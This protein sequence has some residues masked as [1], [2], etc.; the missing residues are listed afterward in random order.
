MDGG[1]FGAANV[2]L[3]GIFIAIDINQTPDAVRRCVELVRTCHESLQKLITLRNKH[4]DFL[5][6]DYPE[7][8]AHANDIIDNANRGIAEVAALVE[9][10]RPD[11]DGTTTFGQRFRWVIADK[12]EFEF[13]QPLITNLHSAVIAETQNLR[14]ITRLHQFEDRMISGRAGSGGGK[15]NGPTQ[16]ANSGAFENMGAL[17]DILGGDPNV[18][19]QISPP[20]PPYT[21]PKPAA[22]MPV[23]GS[24]GAGPA[25]ASSWSQ[26]AAQTG[27]VQMP[28]SGSIWVGTGSSGSTTQGPRPNT[29][30]GNQGMMAQGQ[31]SSHWNQTML[32]QNNMMGSQA[33]QSPGLYS[34]ASASGN[35][36]GNSQGI[37]NTR[38]A[39]NG[40]TMH[41]QQS[42][43][44]NL[45]GTSGTMMSSSSQQNTLL[46][47]PPP[48]NP[49]LGQQQQPATGIYSNVSTTGQPLVSQPQNTQQQVQP[50]IGV[51]SGSGQ[52]PVNIVF[53][54]GQPQ[55]PIGLVNVQQGNS[56]GFHP[57]QTAPI[58]TGIHGQDNT[59]Q[60]SP[61]SIIS[62]P[63]QPTQST[64]GGGQGIMNQ[65][66]MVNVSSTGI[67]QQHSPLHQSTSPQ[68]Q[69]QPESQFQPQG[70]SQFQQQAQPN[71]I[72]NAM[73][74]SQ[75]S[76]MDLQNQSQAANG[77]A[78]T[79]YNASQGQNTMQIPPTSTSI[80]PQQQPV[81]TATPLS[82]IPNY[83]LYGHQPPTVGTMH[84]TNTTQGFHT[85]QAPVSGT[86]QNAAID[87]SKPLPPAPRDSISSQ[88][89]S[90]ISS[91][92]AG[93]NPQQHQRQQEAQG[94]T[95]AHP[96]HHQQQQQEFQNQNPQSQVF[97]PSTDQ[98][99][100][101]APSRKGT[102]FGD[103]KIP[104]PGAMPIMTAASSFSISGRPSLASTTGTVSSKCAPNVNGDSSSGVAPAGAR[105][106]QTSV[107]ASAGGQV[108]EHPGIRSQSVAV[109]AITRKDT[110]ASIQRSATYGSGEPSVNI[111]GNQAHPTASTSSTPMTTS[112]YTTSDADCKAA[113][114]SKKEADFFNTFMYM[115]Q[116]ASPPSTSDVNPQEKTEEHQ[117]QQPQE[118]QQQQYAAH[119][120]QEQQQYQQCQPQQYAHKQ[121]QKEQY[122]PQ[123]QQQEQ[124]LQITQASV[125]PPPSTNT[126]SPSQQQQPIQSPP[127]TSQS[128]QSHQPP[129]QQ[130]QP[131]QQHS[132]IPALTQQPT[133]APPRQQHQ[134][135]QPTSS[136][137]Y[138]T[139]LATPS[140]NVS[141]ISR[142]Q[143]TVSS[144]TSNPNSGGTKFTSPDR[145]PPA[146]LGQYQHQQQGQ[147]GYAGWGAWGYGPPGGPGPGPG[148]A[149]GHPPGHAPYGWGP[150]PQGYYAGYGH[151]P[152]GAG[153]NAYYEAHGRYPP[154]G[155]G[156]HGHS[157]YGGH[158]YQY[159]AAPQEGEGASTSGPSLPATSVHSEGMRYG[160]AAIVAPDPAA[161]VS[162]L[163]MENYWAS[164]QA[165][166]PVELGG[167][168]WGPPP[169][170]PSNGGGGG[171]DNAAELGNNGRRHEMDG[172][173][174]GGARHDPPPREGFHEMGD[175]G[176]GGGIGIGRGGKAEVH[177][178]TESRR[179]TAD[180]NKQAVVVEEKPV[181]Q[182]NW[183]YEFY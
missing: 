87:T 17:A 31:Q 41:N 121:Q 70:Q 94:Q 80:H 159:H 5:T 23:G 132:P 18:G 54:S 103:F 125:H 171:G 1:V 40:A 61:Q 107:N 77:M 69:P 128:S 127:P 172:S 158:P 75:N 34:N 113:R 86:A 133:Q 150:G 98:E 145:A 160:S 32:P 166:P 88:M 165:G 180:E 110:F 117:H 105:Q 143:S 39:Q 2:A 33:Q 60:T 59:Q 126:P 131:R 114:A 12:K 182:N 112:G 102:G 38:P 51:V 63:Q 122:P 24:G 93:P 119:H 71:V 36:Y 170:A 138:T 164:S 82:T 14:Q 109:P 66:S 11:V 183:G 151:P 30:I 46:S 57:T 20:P 85:A 78:Q 100:H 149:Y 15:W 178:V 129:Q 44:S 147:Y 161:G 142:P 13:Q 55:Q 101:P 35:V 108:S 157:P 95:E 154:P 49:T 72:G 144:L 153:P 135:S 152:S 177:V 7:D 65:Q 155:P 167:G 76:N 123:N 68:P 179:K 97:N 16:K 6:Q 111:S 148:Y 90:M 163:G 79:N 136:A 89:G 162:E 10:G 53:T 96:N 173:G 25:S 74:L 168:E 134:I 115:G 45:L 181:P 22:T 42:P 56:Y 91:S 104:G 116:E 47:Q 84:T 140:T 146:R 141:S 26:T 8:L 118:H 19:S 3:H 130:Q 124:Q 67:Y 50:L 21:G 58:G 29:S 27:G 169:A 176:G 106:S 64:I 9:K 83:M 99:H 81:S 92:F 52:Q 137:T 28:A 156:A 37:M 139:S 73:N 175:S 174:A 62:Q 4:L 48:M 43:T 120:D